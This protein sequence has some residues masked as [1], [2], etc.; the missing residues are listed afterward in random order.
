MSQCVNE[1]KRQCVNA[2]IVRIVWI[3]KIVEFVY[4]SLSGLFGLFGYSG[5]EKPGAEKQH[6]R[7]ACQVED[8]IA[9]GALTAGYG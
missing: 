5:F 1:M 6:H 2:V 4:S 7:D 3:V 9:D 8:D